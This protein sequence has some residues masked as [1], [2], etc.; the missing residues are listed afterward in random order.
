MVWW[1]RLCASTAGGVG[2]IPGP[3][4]KIL[5]ELRSCVPLGTTKKTKKIC[6]ARE[7]AKVARGKGFL[8]PF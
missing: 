8:S 4:T 1:L 5:H 7:G 3:G 2:L 6:C